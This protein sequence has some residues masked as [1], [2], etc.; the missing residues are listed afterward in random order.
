[1]SI[2]L[3]RKLN[4][5][6]QVLGMTWSADSKLIATTEGLNWTIEIWEAA[7]GA[8]INIIHKQPGGGVGIL[9]TPDGKSVITPSLDSPQVAFA[10]IDI[11]T[12]QPVRSVIGPNDTSDFAAANQ[13][14]FFTLSPDGEN[15]FVSFN[16]PDTHIH[17]YNTS[18]WAEIGTIPDLA[19]R[20][21]GGPADDELTTLAPDG[22]VRIWNVRNRT[23]TRQFAL[24]EHCNEMA[25]SAKACLIA[26]AKPDGKNLNMSTGQIESGF[27][28]RP[29][30]LWSLDKT[31]LIG[32]G[33][34]MQPVAG[35]VF[36]PDATL[37]ATVTG[38][39]SVVVFPTHD[40][41][42]AQT[43]VQFKA[44]ASAIAFSPDG[45]SL[46]AAGDSRIVIF[47]VQ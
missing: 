15:L 47:N 3:A 34:A 13:P 10:L 4:L 28:E 5:E 23:L 27:D 30:Y 36:N 22:T 1:M 43:L 8:L 19:Y 9:F 26:T 31:F 40:L 2:T 14:K 17:I 21:S 33:S 24:Q 37:L 18:T 41:S 12:G 6:T 11:H 45:R 32:R 29:I 7:T 46:A 39:K 16:L 44:H 42:A 35:L 38:S 20:M 25:I